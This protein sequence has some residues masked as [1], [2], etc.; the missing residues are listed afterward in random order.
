MKFYKWLNDAVT[1]ADVATYDKKI[2]DK[3]TTEEDSIEV[4]LKDNSFIDI[5]KSLISKRKDVTMSQ[6]GK[7]ITIQGPTEKIRQVEMELKELGVR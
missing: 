6:D 5:I 4:V 7:V 1:S 2:G 3:G